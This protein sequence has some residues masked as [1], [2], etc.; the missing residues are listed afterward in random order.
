MPPGPLPINPPLPGAMMKLPRPVLPPIADP[1]PI[2]GGPESGRA[3]FAGPAPIVGG[4]GGGIDMIMLPRTLPGAIIG[5]AGAPPPNEEMA[6]DV[7]IGRYAFVEAVN[8][9]FVDE[10]N[11]FTGADACSSGGAPNGSLDGNGAEEPAVNEPRPVTPAGKPT[12]V[13]LLLLLLLTPPL[14]CISSFSDGPPWLMLARRVVSFARPERSKSTRLVCQG[15]LGAVASSL[16]AT[17]SAAATAA[18]GGVCWLA[19]LAASC[20]AGVGP[21]DKPAKSSKADPLRAGAAVAVF[22]GCA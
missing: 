12:L 22:A 2:A 16:T 4:I 14:V 1:P 7:D 11:G 21:Y 6:S 13:V 3:P 20:C 10:E 8:R 18:G 9:S 17:G 15:S 5:A 19:R